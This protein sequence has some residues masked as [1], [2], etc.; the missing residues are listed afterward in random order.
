MLNFY[1][2]FLRRAAGA[3]GAAGVAGAPLMDA[4][5]GPGKSLDLT[6]AL[7]SAF[8]RAKDLPAAVP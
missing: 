8:H 4:L 3:A 6:P 7:D 2:K 1:R 5:R